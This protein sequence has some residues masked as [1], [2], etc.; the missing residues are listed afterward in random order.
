MAL[1][2]ESLEASGTMAKDA[3]KRDIQLQRKEPPI[4][5]ARRGYCSVS[6]REGSFCVSVEGGAQVAERN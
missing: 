1:K 6:R 4:I 2:L 3:N 5:R